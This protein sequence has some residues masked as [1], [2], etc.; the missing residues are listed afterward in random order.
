MLNII[1]QKEMQ[2]KTMMKYHYTPS[3]IATIKKTDTIKCWLGCGIIRIFVYYWW[4]YKVNFNP[5]LLEKNINIYLFS[6]NS[7]TNI[8]LVIDDT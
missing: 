7:V 5:C 4:E 3:E 6:T 2:V 8:I 1:S